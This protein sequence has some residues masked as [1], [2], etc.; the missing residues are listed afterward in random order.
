MLHVI[1]IVCIE[2]QDFQ[3]SQYVKTHLTEL[4]LFLTL[5]NELLM[6]LL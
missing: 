2:T 6:N 3:S 4:K 1:I 5:R